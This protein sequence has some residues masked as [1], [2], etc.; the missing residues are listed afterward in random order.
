MLRG[1]LDIGPHA[2]ELMSPENCY[3]LNCVPKEDVRVLTPYTNPAAL[4]SG[5]LPHH[6]QGYYVDCHSIYC[7][8]TPLA[9]AGGPGVGAGPMLNLSLGVR[10]G[11]N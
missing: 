2:K 5:N 9:I 4:F 7:D 11:T 3:G 1:A 10:I 6:S 8:F